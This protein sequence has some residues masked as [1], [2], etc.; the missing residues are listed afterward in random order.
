[1]KKLV[2]TCDKCGNECEN[3]YF[4]VYR[5]KI[6][7]DMETVSGRADICSNCYNRM[8]SVLEANNE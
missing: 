1:M 3:H 2:I 8:L 5:N 6:T 7:M 4:T